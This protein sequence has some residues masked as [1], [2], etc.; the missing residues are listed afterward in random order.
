MVPAVI[1]IAGEG[2][3]CVRVPRCTWRW[4]TMKDIITDEVVRHGVGRD[5]KNSKI[6]VKD[7]EEI[8]C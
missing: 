5:K 8:Y 1:G 7:E 3:G 4:G 6:I 2:K